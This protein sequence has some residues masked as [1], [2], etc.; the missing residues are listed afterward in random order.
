VP[1]HS[2]LAGGLGAALGM[3]DDLK[4]GFVEEA[5]RWKTD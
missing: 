1:E 2:T 4:E 3:S 5:K